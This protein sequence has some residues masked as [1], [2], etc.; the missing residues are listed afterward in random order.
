MVTTRMSDMVPITMP[1]AVRAKRTLLVR[2][3]SMAM[4]TISLK[5]IVLVAVSV[6]E[7][8]V[9]LL[10]YPE[11]SE[12]SLLLCC[13][14]GINHSQLECPFISQLECP[15]ILGVRLRR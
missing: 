5:S 11:L 3:E 6:R 8:R 13:T 12:G 15:F 7:R 1:S 4:L 10:F 2:N 9:M 14:R